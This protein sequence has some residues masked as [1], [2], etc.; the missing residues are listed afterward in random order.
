[1]VRAVAKRHGWKVV[2]TYTDD[3]I[4]GAKGRDKRPGRGGGAYNGPAGSNEL[5]S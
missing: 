4:S 3:G 2:A 5:S 1:M